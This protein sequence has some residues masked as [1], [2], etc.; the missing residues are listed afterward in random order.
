MRP[1]K[2]EAWDKKMERM[3]VVLSLSWIGSGE[4][5]TPF[6]VNGVI[7][8]DRFEL[9]EFTGL[10]DKKGKEIYEK[11]IVKSKG[12]IGYIYWCWSRPGFRLVIRNKKTN[13]RKAFKIDILDGF[14][15]IGNIYK[16]KNLIKETNGN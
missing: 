9:R 10:K 2:Y 11:D 16:N 7:N 6:R 8:S 5:G 15:I 14:E 4:Q 12:K 3:V 1:I 13:H